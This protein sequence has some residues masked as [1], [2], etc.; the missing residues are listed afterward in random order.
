MLTGIFVKIVSRRVSYVYLKLNFSGGH[1]GFVRFFH[2]IYV[3]L[4][5]GP[6][7]NVARRKVLRMASTLEYGHFRSVSSSIAGD[8]LARAEHATVYVL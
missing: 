6:E 5:P 4:V 3:T 8:I 1:S 2:S 7:I